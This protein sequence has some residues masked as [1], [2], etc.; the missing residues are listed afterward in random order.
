[1]GTY[2]G[3]NIRTTEFGG[4]DLC[5]EYG[6]FLPLSMSRE[7]AIAINDS[8]PALLAIYPDYAAY[9]IKLRNA[10]DNLVLQRLL[11]EEDADLLLNRVEQSINM[12]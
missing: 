11:L 6:S 8:R 1:M 5:D 2:L 7:D 3:W 9:V 12:H 10:I 4:G